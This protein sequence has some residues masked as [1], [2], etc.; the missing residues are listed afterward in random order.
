MFANRILCNVRQY[1]NIFLLFNQNV[2]YAL[3]SCTSQ[4][5]SCIL[6]EYESGTLPT[7]PGNER[8]ID[9]SFPSRVA[10]D[11]L[12]IITSMRDNSRL[13]PT[14]RLASTIRATV[15]EF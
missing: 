14:C 3:C 11:L 9:R 12:I 1:Y 7:V 5:L 4:S 15:H 13:V 8:I 6:A 10:I 2:G